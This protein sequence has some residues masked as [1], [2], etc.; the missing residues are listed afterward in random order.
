MRVTPLVGEK[1]WFGPR[2]HGWGWRPISWEGWVVLV[3]SAVASLGIRIWLHREHREW[4]RRSRMLSG[5]AVLG[6][7]VLKGTA[8]GGARQAAEFDAAQ[9]P[10]TGAL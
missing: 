9:L 3:G 7:M 1:L 4:E 6:V 10:G 5:V 8:P 2:R